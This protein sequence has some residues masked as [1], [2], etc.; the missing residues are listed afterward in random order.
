VANLDIGPRLARADHYTIT[1]Y[2]NIGN[3]HTRKV[4]DAEPKYSWH[5]M[6]KDGAVTDLMN[7]DWIQTFATCQNLNAIWEIFSNV[8]NTVIQARVPTRK[9]TNLKQRYPKHIRKLINKKR[10]LHRRLVI[11]PNTSLSQNIDNLDMAIGN[12]MF[13]HAK[14][15]EAKF[16][17]NARGDQKILPLYSNKNEIEIPH[18]STEWS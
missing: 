15:E 5:N 10:E 7:V 14:A 6:D 8:M 16:L 11:E 9:P 2:V 12:E 13:A 18:R 3:T 1:F 17:N 4:A